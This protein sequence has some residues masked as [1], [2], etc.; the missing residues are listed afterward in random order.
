MSRAIIIVTLSA[1]TSLT[2]LKHKVGPYYDQKI[3][4]TSSSRKLPIISNIYFP[5]CGQYIKQTKHLSWLGESNSMYYTKQGREEYSASQWCI[6][7]LYKEWYVQKLFI[8]TS[9]QL[10]NQYMS[11]PFHMSSTCTIH[12]QANLERFLADQN[13]PVTTYII[14]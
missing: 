7:P 10:M 14:W 12:V 3:I 4:K 8:L 2:H 13:R 9:H 5:Y 11:R 1:K 6:L